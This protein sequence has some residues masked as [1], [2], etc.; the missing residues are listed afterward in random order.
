MQHRLTRIAF[1]FVVVALA[2]VIVASSPPPAFSGVVPPTLTKSFSPTTINAGGTTVLTFTVTNVTGAPAVSN[3]GFT[4]YLPSG[5]VV[6]NPPSVGGTCANAAA[7]T[8]TSGGSGTITVSNLQVP[9][10]ATPCT[11]TVNVTNAS[12][13][14]NS[15]C[16]GNPPA[17]T[18]SSG[19][20]TVSNAVNGVTPS[21]LVVLGAT[22]TPTNTPTGIPT[23]APT[24]TPPG[25]PF[26]SQSAVVPTLSFP[27][28]GLLA[29]CLL[30]VGFVLMRRS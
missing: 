19:N 10:G 11:V 28:L 24:N 16:V 30:G 17:F 5:L 27:M 25:T 6:A 18:N 23:N 22:N 2:S 15:S 20:V 9:A 21:C 3:V 26:P 13:Q 29:L 12:G 8:V 14:S 1:R 7:A 4:E